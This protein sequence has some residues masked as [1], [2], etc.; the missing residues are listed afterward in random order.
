M[1]KQN[2]SWYADWRDAE[3]KR[4]RKAFPTKAAAE[5]HQQRQQQKARTKK[6]QG[7]ASSK[8]SVSSTPA[9][10]TNELTKH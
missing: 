8:T 1:K 6:A 7:L 2:G 9:A 5:N 10:M 4:H 3:G